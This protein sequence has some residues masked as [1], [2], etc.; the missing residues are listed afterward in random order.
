M[1]L[2]KIVIIFPYFGKFPP[3]YEAWRQTAIINFNVDFMFFTDQ[4]V[5]PA[6][7]IIVHSM[8]FSNFQKLVQAAFDFPVVLNR[9]YKLCEYKQA[10][11]YILHDYIKDYDFWGFGDLD[12]VYG[13]IRSFLTDSV[14]EHKFVLGWGHLTLIRND[15]DA[16]TY[17]TKQVKGYQYYKDAFTTSKIT[18]FDEFDHKGCSDKWRD[19]RF[20]DCWLEEPFDNVSKPKQAYHFNSLNRGWKQVLFEHVD[21]KLYM[22]RFNKGKLEKKESLYAHFQHRGFMKNTV[23]DY[24]HFLITPGAIIDYPKRFVILRLHLLCRKRRLMTKYYQWRD[25]I[26]WR[27]HLSY[28]R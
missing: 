18:F 24:S 5:E 28:Q 2:L 15:E 14:L 16:N 20:E 3:Q 8:Q 19:C 13:D 26:I 22:L 21:N 25:Y 11:G 1:N 27:L 12:L 17:F 6:K 10:Y 4:E 7:N 9:P 23:T